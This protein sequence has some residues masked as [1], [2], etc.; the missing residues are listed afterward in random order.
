M[1]TPLETDLTTPLA[2][3]LAHSGLERI[4]YEGFLRPEKVE[5]LSGIY[6]MEPYQPGKIP[7]LL[8]HGL[9]SSPETWATLY[10]DLRADP[11]LRER[12]QFWF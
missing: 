4:S 1:T 5:R 7:V 8:V 3:L 2:Y 6:L 9:L 12:Y 10:N 11:V